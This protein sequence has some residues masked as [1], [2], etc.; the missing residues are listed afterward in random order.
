MN[1][2]ELR[3]RRL[4]GVR[5]TLILLCVAA[6]A[7]LGLCCLYFLLVERYPFLSFGCV[8]S[9]VLHLYCPGCGG[10]RAVGALLRGDILTSLRCHPV[11]LWICMICVVQFV[12]MLTALLRRDPD[13][14]A[15]PNWCWIGM[16]VLLI[17]VFVVRNLLMICFG[18]DYLGDNLAFWSQIRL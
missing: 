8:M 6:V 14:A 4:A 2:E 10:T 7:L 11:V 18:Y 15:F 1:N 17:G 16:I 3:E 13:R 9:R 12:R 5:L